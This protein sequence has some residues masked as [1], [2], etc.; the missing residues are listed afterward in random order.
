MK[1]A[2]QATKEDAKGEEEEQEEEGDASKQ[3]SI[4]SVV[5]ACSEL[6][7]AFGIVPISKASASVSFL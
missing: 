3:A 7:R 1:R 2:T 4:G 6:P 5:T